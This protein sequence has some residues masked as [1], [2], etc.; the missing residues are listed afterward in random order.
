MGSSSIGSSGWFICVQTEGPRPGGAINSGSTLTFA[1]IASFS[2]WE[3]RSAE[4]RVLLSVAGDS[5]GI[6]AF[7]TGGLGGGFG[8]LAR[9]A[10]V[11]PIATLEVV[12][13]RWIKSCFG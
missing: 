4:G 2:F 9:W 1:P 6:G 5:E 10:Q 11:A 12:R 13:G 8:A 3:K 7:G